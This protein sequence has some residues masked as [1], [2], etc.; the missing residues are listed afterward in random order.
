MPKVLFICIDDTDTEN[1]IG[2]GRLARELARQIEQ[3]SLGEV[4]G[5]TRHQLL[6]H[7]DIPYTSNNGNACLEVWNFKAAI[8]EM[9]QE[10]MKVHF[11][12]G[13]DPGLCICPKESVT[14]EVVQFGK[15]AQREVVS[16]EKAHQV[17][18][19]AK[20]FLK[21]LGGTGRGVIGALA[22]VGLRGTGNDGRFIE[23][24]GIRNILGQVRVKEI[25][26]K[27]AIQLVVDLQGRHLPPEAVIDSGGWLRPYL[28]SGVP[29]LIVGGPT[30]GGIKGD[31]EG[32]YVPVRL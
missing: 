23:L 16:K 21:E 7:Q 6:L 2:T 11:M 32:F 4:H 20:V 18:R 24:P 26:E 29:T 28:R 15:L 27:T 12:P 13:S 30:A 17:A 25:L 1:S 14:L 9:A 31:S 19:Q 3:E 10:F 5:I 22:G 8:Y